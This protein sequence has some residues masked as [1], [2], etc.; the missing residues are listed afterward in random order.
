MYCRNHTSYANFK[1]KLC[2]KFQLEILTE[3]EVSGI[4]Y[5]S[6][7]ILESLW[8]VSETAPKSGFAFLEFGAQDVSSDILWLQSS[9]Y[10]LTLEATLI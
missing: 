2:T 7:I 6:E 5:F 1:L 10:S 3:N 8:D 4:V 9:V